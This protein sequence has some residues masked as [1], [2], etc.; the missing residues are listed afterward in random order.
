[1][2]SEPESFFLQNAARVPLG[3]SLTLGTGESALVCLYGL[4]SG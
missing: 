2:L 3:L 1:M 4:S